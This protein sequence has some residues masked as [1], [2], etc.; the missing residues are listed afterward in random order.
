MANDNGKRLI[1]EA[2]NLHAQAMSI[3]NSGEGGDGLTPEQNAQ[4]DKLLD[5]VESKTAHAKRLTRAE[6]QNDFLNKPDDAKKSKD[7]FREGMEDEDD[8]PPRDQKGKGKGKGT[9]S[10]ERKAFDKALAL[11]TLTME[12]RGALQRKDLS[13][14]VSDAGGTLLAPQEFVA[15]IIAALENE[16][17]VRQ[18]T[19]V[20]T[21]IKAVSLGVPT[22]E[23][24]VSDPDWS[25]EIA[26]GTKDTALKTGKREFFP[27]PLAKRVLLS[28]RFVRTSAIPADKLVRDRLVYKFGVAQENAF[29]NGNGAEQPL[30][31]FVASAQGINTDRDTIAAGATA[32]VGDDVLNTFYA[33]KPQYSQD[34]TWVMHRLVL[35]EM[36]KIKTSFGEYI[37]QPGLSTDRPATLLDRPYKVSE[38]APSAM[39]ASQYVAIF[40]NFKYYWIVDALEMEIQVVDQLYAETNQIGYIGRAE[41]DGMPV[42]SE[43]FARLQ[44]HS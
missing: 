4:V 3:L 8:E 43:A 24:D 14:D 40:G 23:A 19:D 1:E 13:G 25:A 32:I 31:V 5:E 7:M 29:L 41:V 42:L 12:E 17:F 20:Q 30:G 16:V 9:R 39:T 18:L 38:Y 21:L 36:R 27:H 22:L 2:A 44:L 33:L 6:A 26:T 35:R 11:Q 10:L 15:E 28:R 34:A 37:W